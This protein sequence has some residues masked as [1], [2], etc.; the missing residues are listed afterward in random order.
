[1]SLTWLLYMQ[2]LHVCSVL[3]TVLVVVWL[4]IRLCSGR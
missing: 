4:V 3:L 2:A 1:M